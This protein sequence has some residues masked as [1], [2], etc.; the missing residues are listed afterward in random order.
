M[1]DLVLDSCEETEKKTCIFWLERHTRNTK[2]KIGKPYMFYER[3]NQGQCDSDDADVW[4]GGYFRL[5][6][7]VV[8]PL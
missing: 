8:F 7:E 6:N 5:G 3:T 2:Q 4:S 1:P